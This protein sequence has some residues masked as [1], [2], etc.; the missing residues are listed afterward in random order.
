MALVELDNEWRRRNIKIA[1]RDLRA[2]DEVSMASQI[3]EAGAYSLQHPSD[4][5]AF[6]GLRRCRPRKGIARMASAV[7]RS[8]KLAYALF[9]RA[10]VCCVFNHTFLRSTA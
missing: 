3:F 10:T 9:A 1:G 5:S 7:E 6:I 8:Q 4:R 2:L